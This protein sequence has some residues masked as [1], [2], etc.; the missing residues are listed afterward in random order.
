MGDGTAS[1][2]AGHTRAIGN[3]LVTDIT[4]AGVAQPVIQN[5]SGYTGARLVKGALRVRGTSAKSAVDGVVGS[6]VGISVPVT[7]RFYPG[8]NAISSAMIN[9]PLLFAGIAPDLTDAQLQALTASNG[10]LTDFL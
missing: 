9:S 3:N 10:L 8:T 5:R 4:T 2:F 6:E 1:N 7:D